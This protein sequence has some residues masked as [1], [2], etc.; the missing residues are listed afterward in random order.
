MATENGHNGYHGHHL[1]E[2]IK[3]APAP[4]VVR[5]AN[6]APLRL[7]GFALMT[8]VLSCYNAATSESP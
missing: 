2:A 3:A 4:H 1:E 8:F 7:W 6:P 5:I